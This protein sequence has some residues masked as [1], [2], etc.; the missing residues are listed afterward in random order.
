[1]DQKIYFGSIREACRRNLGNLVDDP[2]FVELFDLF[3]HVGL[4]KNTYLDHLLEYA[5]VFVDSK[6]RRLRLSVFGVMN[7]LPQSVPRTK[8]A[9]IKRA[10]RK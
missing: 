10:Y 5:Q 1:M 4:G 8:V 2:D 9:L 6:K 7:K 3:M